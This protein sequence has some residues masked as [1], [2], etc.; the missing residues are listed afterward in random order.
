[1]LGQGCWECGNPVSYKNTNCPY[2]IGHTCHC[3]YYEAELDEDF[4]AWSDLHIDPFGRMD[5]FCM[6]C[7]NNNHRQSCNCHRR[8]IPYLFSHL[9]KK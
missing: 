4:A 5:D 6:V 8:L 7:G 2:G 1:M 9:E 3:S